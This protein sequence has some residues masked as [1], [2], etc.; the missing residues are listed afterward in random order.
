[1]VEYL[2]QIPRTLVGVFRNGDLRRVELAYI[3][4]NAAE[5][6]VW[7]AMLVYAYDRGGA[8]TAGVV[9]LAQ[10]VPAALFATLAA[11][12]AD[13]YP[14][15]HVLVL[16]YLTQALA[17]AA[18]GAV[19]LLGGTPIAAY[20]CAAVAATAVTLTR[21]AQAVLAPALARTPD[22]LT[23]TNVTS[24][25]I[26]SV[27]MLAA[28]AAA[29]VLL[30]AGGAGTVFAVMAVV[31]LLAAL[32]VA[33][34]QSPALHQAEE[35]RGGTW[36]AISVT[37]REPATRAIVWLLGVESVAIGALDVLYVVL[38]VGVLHDSGSTAGYLNAAFGAGGVLGIA[39]TV[40]LVGRSTLA[41]P[42]LLALAAWATALVALGI[43][44]SPWSAFP[45]LA[46]AGAGRA[47]LDVAGRTLLQ[48]LAPPDTLARV[49]GILEGVSMA[50]LAVGSVAA[51]SL[52]AVAGGRG[53]FIGVGLLLPT[54]LALVYRSIRDAD[55]QA[56]PLVELTR[57]RA[58]P[59][60]SL[61]PRPQL[62]ALAR[63]ANPLEVSPGTAIV[64]KGGPGDLF[65][66][67]TGGAADVHIHGRL[68]RELSPGDHFGEIALLKD[69]PRTA[70]VTARTQCFL[71][72]L[73]K[74]A[75]LEAV[76]GHAASHAA[77]TKVVR[78]RIEHTALT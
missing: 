65:Y 26:E 37:A 70:T 60:F 36:E 47:V 14:P 73:D 20:A 7:I 31:V 16:A 24:G 63:A 58:V 78:E 34:L 69:S 28:P 75:F 76:T 49:F 23:A 66:V 38:A 42:L 17:M 59:L 4:F 5:W 6:G 18:T 29:A 35:D 22:E 55:R 62:E 30:A 46:V 13:R 2:S 11:S 61:L 27:S 15:K 68:V 48:R 12:L 39:A 33:P 45:L 32:V 43:A 10:L 64:R 56:L 21:P 19:L 25:W 74:A 71:L 8:T 57:L 67:I 41:P 3:G 50:G 53:A 9:A 1:M 52:V 40:A 44:P 54:A 77:A 72:A 51:A